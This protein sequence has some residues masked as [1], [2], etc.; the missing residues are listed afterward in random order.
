MEGEVRRE[1]D[2]EWSKKDM[3]LCLLAQSWRQ[4]VSMVVSVGRMLT[5]WR[6]AIVTRPLR[7]QTGVGEKIAMK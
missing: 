7:M 6:D 3:T 4:L 2:G 5:E 1:Q